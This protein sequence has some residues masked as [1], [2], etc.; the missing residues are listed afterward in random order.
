MKR[1]KRC[2]EH[3]KVE[4]LYLCPRCKRRYCKQCYEWTNTYGACE[5]CEEIIYGPKLIKIEKE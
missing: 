1:V 3:P 2:S 4:A 5:D